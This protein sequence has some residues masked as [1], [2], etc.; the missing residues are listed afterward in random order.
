MTDHVKP[1]QEELLNNINTTLAQ[2]SEP[3][4]T[5]D[6]PAEQKEVKAVETTQEE[7][8]QEVQVEEKQE[9]PEKQEATEEKVE[10]V[11]AEE[12]ETQDD[13]DVVDYKKKYV[14]SS[15]EA[16]KLFAEKRKISEALEKVSTQEPPTEEDLK[17][18]YPEWD[19]LSDF[20]K[21]MATE[22]LVNKRIIQSLDQ[23]TQESKEIE[24]WYEVVN[25]FAQNPKTLL[26]YPELEGKIEDFKA[27]A[28]DK[29]RRKTDFKDIV[30][31]FL[32]TWTQ[33]HTKRSKGK[34]FEDGRG[35]PKTKPQTSPGKMSFADAQVLRNSNYD[36]YKRLMLSGAI[37]EPTL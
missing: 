24:K 23:V 16:Q 25:T 17:K 26:N 18:E 7:S 9:E 37:E 22:N 6:E 13:S 30:G 19:E 33:S 15:R 35:G 12:T 21:R 3:S 27:F 34:M 10:E 32:Y 11:K 8:K 20:E 2:L 4:I 5:K 31:S 36:E 29:S 1:S 28:S 14:D